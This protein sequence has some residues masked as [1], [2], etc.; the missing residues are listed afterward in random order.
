MKFKKDDKGKLELDEKGDPIAITEEG[1]TIPLDKV[2]SLGKHTRVETERDELKTENAKLTTQ[3]GELSKLTGDKEALEKRITEITEGSEKTKTDLEA[4]LATRDKEYAL[5]TALLGAG[6]SEK[7]LKAAHAYVDMEKITVADGKL[8]GLDL[9]SFKKEN[10]FL[11][12]PPV[13]V[14]SAAAS[15]S[16]GGTDPSEARLAAAMGLSEE[17]KE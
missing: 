4:R 10:D 12:G 5:D 9:E 6:V 3:I 8:S 16:A 14:D 7:K 2:V 15:R 13:K 1:E 17:K 11:F